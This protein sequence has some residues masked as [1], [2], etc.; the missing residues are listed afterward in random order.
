LTVVSKP[1]GTIEVDEKQKVIFP[2]GLFG[3][4][5][6]KEYV[7]LDS[8]RQPFYWLQSLDSA[9][10]AFVLLDPF[11]FRPDYEMDINDDELAQIG[12]HS[13]ENAIYFAI[14]T[15]PQDGNPMTA[16]LQGPIV[17]NRENHL[18]KQV[19]LNDPRWKTKHDVQKELSEFNSKNGSKKAPC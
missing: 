6:F 7:L 13:P 8:E 15:I 2:E 14:L 18:A 10:T 11:L 17:I 19:I 16:N 3:F 4:E 1:Y 12:V 9:G 5:S